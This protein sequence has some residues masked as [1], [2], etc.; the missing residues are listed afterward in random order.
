MAY[1]VFSFEAK[2]SNNA[3]GHHVRP[4]FLPTD[5][6]SDA[7]KALR[8]GFKERVAA[9]HRTPPEALIKA[10]HD[11]ANTKRRERLPSADGSAPE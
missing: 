3:R 5:H 9:E 1:N 7:P 10:I 4:P 2:A 6:G 8:D 11:R